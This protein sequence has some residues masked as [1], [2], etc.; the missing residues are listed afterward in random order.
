MNNVKDTLLRLLRE[1]AVPALQEAMQFIGST[2]E[3]LV[4]ALGTSSTDRHRYK[5]DFG[6]VDTLLSRSY[7]GFCP[8]GRRQL[9]SLHSQRN[10]MLC[11]STG[12][13]KTQVVCLPTILKAHGSFFINDPSGEIFASTSGA[14]A[15]K[16][17]DIKVI[18]FTKDIDGYNPLARVKDTSDANKI[19]HL[20]VRSTLGNNSSDPFWSIQAVS[21]ISLMMSLLRNEPERYRNLANVRHLLLCLTA[22]PLLVDAVVARSGDAQAIQEYKSFL[23]FDVKLRTSIQATCL[24]ALQ[25]FTDPSVARVTAHD[26]IDLGQL[27]KR[28]TTIYIHCNTSD[29]KY[30][31]TLISILFE[32]ATKSIMSSLPTGNDLPVYFIL[33][34]CSS[35]Y[36]PTLQVTAANCRKYE[37]GLLII[38]QAYEQLVDIYGKHEAES[39][40]SNCFAR[41]YMGATSHPTSVELSQQLGRYEWEDDKGKKHLRELMLPEEIRQ[42]A[43]NRALLI[44]SNYAPL[45][46]KL[47]P[48]YDNP[49]LRLKTKLPPVGL[50]QHIPDTEVP[51]LTE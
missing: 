44:C 21:L 7:H 41:M 2:L 35:L 1:Y 18:D 39:I 20:L 47:T 17:Y 32:Q 28:K 27:R 46:L 38:L 43:S 40:R 26:T 49:F 10:M 37:A 51:L 8:D 33:D 6:T 42:M 12:M 15:Q 3:A 34:E 4:T 11:A 25:V 22:N 19:A 9:S 31:S 30:Y 14:L 45:M 48:A 23:A 16:G 50:K 5:A 29:M 24:A 13:G 36:L